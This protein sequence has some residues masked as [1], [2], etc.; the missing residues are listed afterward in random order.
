MNYL[1]GIDFGGGASKL[2]LINTE[3]NI[4]FENTVEYP[5][6]Y[7]EIGACEQKPSDWIE[8]LCKNCKALFSN[9]GVKPSE[10]LAVALDSATHSF[11]LCDESGMPLMDA[12]HWTDLRSRPQADLLARYHGEEIFKKAFHAPGTIWTLPQ[13]LWLKENRGEVFSRARHLFFEKD[14]IRFF[15]TGIFCTDYIEAEGSM[16]FDCNKMTWDDT[17]CRLAGISPKILPPIV[18][19]TDTVGTVTSEAS[20]LTGLREETKVI[21]GTTDTA[22]EVFAA[23]AVKE[24]DMT[25]KLATAGRICVI[26]D[27]PYPDHNLVNYSHISHGLWYPGTATKS[28]AASYRWYRDSFGESYKELDDKAAKIPPGAEGIIFHPYLKGE[29]TPLSDPDVRGSF[30]GIGAHHSKSHFTRAVLEGV[31]FSLLD[32]KKY[33]DSLGIPYNKDSAALIGGGAKSSLWSQITSD[34]LGI[35]LRITESSDSSLGSAMLAGIACGVFTDPQ[36]AVKKC[37]KEK[38]TVFP[39]LHR[40]EE[41]QTVFSR[42]KEVQK[43]L[44]PLYREWNK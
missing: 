9:S 11:L 44:A 19:P 29:I 5:S 22:L 12:V 26:T 6:Y 25:V 8:A 4:I 24:G 41:Y 31:S 17:L 40:H 15:L 27:R 7:P 1:L 16:L 28:A 30:I 35:P 36:D 13:I 37:I 32:S 43:A 38:R 18:M 33:L 39:D 10:I 14:Y 3:G 21:C 23:G 2:T 42:Y 20:R 34:I